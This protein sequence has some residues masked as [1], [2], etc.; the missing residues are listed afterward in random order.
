MVAGMASEAF[1][2]GF[3]GLSTQLS[4]FTTLENSHASV[5]TT[6]FNQ[7]LIP[8]LSWSYT[9]GAL[10]YKGSLHLS[11]SLFLFFLFFRVMLNL[12][13][14]LGLKKVLGQLI[15]GDYDRSRTNR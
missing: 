13:F 8:S 3:L 2:M 15:F 4:N 1:Y 12:E 7:N 11:F 9:A 5:F 6:L 14:I 10:Y